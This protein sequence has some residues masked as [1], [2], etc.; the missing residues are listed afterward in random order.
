MKRYCS[1]GF[2]E[3]QGIF[4]LAEQLL[5]FRRIFSVGIETAHGLDVRG[6]IPDRGRFLSPP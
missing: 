3:V 2:C 1:L 4:Y 5:A 6:L